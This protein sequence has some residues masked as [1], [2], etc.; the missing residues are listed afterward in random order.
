MP[1]VLAQRNAHGSAARLTH[2][3]S[4]A[5][6]SN[7]WGRM[8]SPQD[9]L[10]D[11]LRAMQPYLDE[12][13]GKPL[14]FCEHRI[15]GHSER[16]QGLSLVSG[17]SCISHKKKANFWRRLCDRFPRLIDFLCNSNDVGQ[18][19]E[20]FPAPAAHVRKCK[21]DLSVRRKD[22]AGNLR[23]AVGGVC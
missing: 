19:T 3:Q 7:R 13:S 22:A 21:L 5:E 18:V 4:S 15:G 14:H 8:C 16:H 20:L 9:E 12:H 1:R 23:R 10:V 17:L 6:R 11:L 2:T